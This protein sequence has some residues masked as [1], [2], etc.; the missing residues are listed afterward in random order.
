MKILHTH[1]GERI[2]MDDDTADF[3]L[4][5]EGE[6]LLRRKAEEEKRTALAAECAFGED[7]EETLAEIRLHARIEQRRERARERE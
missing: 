5:P 2:V 7:D 4:G 1:D 3:L 6:A